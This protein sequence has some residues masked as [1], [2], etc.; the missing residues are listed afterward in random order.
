MDELERSV[1]QPTSE[2]EE[3]AT[4]GFCYCCCCC[5]YCYYY[6]YY[7]RYSFTHPALAAVDGALCLP[8][9]VPPLWPGGSWSSAACPS[10]ARLLLVEDVA[11]ANDRGAHDAGLLL[12]ASASGAPP[13]SGSCTFGGSVPETPTL[14]LNPG[15]T[16]D[17]K[18]AAA[19]V[20]DD[21]EDDMDE[22]D[23]ALAAGGGLG[24]SESSAEEEL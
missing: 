3:P 15:P 14:T 9:A 20:D 11:L 21:A 12:A 8:A 23:M 4:T 24:T 16:D 7:R 19:A 18:A 5:Y 1:G 2:G 6:Y 22:E 17:D 10:A 13:S